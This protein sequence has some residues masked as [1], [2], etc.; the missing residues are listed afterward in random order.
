MKC[1][2]FSEDLGVYG[3]LTKMYEK[4]YSPLFM[5]EIVNLK[6]NETDE[7]KYRTSD[8]SLLSASIVAAM[9]KKGKAVVITCHKY[10]PLLNPQFL[11]DNVLSKLSK[12][13]E[14]IQSK[15]FFNE[16]EEKVDGIEI[17]RIEGKPEKFYGSGDSL[18]NWINFPLSPIMFGQNFENYLTQEFNKIQLKYGK[19]KYFNISGIN[20]FEE[21][22][23]AVFFMGFHSTNSIKTLRDLAFTNGSYDWDGSFIGK[24]FI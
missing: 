12:F 20:V 5:P 18:K 14:F 24:K 21:N 19:L 10:H 7:S 11:N 8:K 3:N 1:A 16:L 6:L 23:C 13:D 15:Q 9:K 2:Y 17:H 22:E 4:G